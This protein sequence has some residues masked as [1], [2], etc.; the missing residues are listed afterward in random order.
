MGRRN[1]VRKPPVEIEL[2]SEKLLG[3]VMDPERWDPGATGRGAALKDD[4]YEILTALVD[5]YGAYLLMGAVA[6]IGMDVGQLPERVAES[7]AQE[8]AE[9][10]VDSWQ[11][12]A[13]AHEEARA[14][15]RW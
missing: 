13:E 5:V 11:A 4:D 8:T 15:R 10:L 9:H 12:E 2:L 3:R 6:Q 1:T 14:E 7:M